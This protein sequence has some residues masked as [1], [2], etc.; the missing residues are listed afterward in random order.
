MDTNTGHRVVELSH[1][2]EHQMTTYPGLP[3]PEVSD[4]LSR[5][6]S[7]QTYPSGTEF[8]IGRISLV[9]NTGTYLDAPFHRY[10][11]GADLSALDLSR[12]AHLPGV[13][14]D[15]TGRG[16][17][18]GPDAFAGHA[19]TDHAV[20]VRT[21]WDRHW[22]TAHY[23]APE[24]PFL[25]IEAVAW[26]V[27]QRAALVGIDSVNID[28]MVDL[29]RPAHTGLLGAGIPIVEHLRGLDQLPDSG[30][31]FHAAP[32]PVRGMGSFPIRAYAVVG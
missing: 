18:I 15:A 31:R 12:L 4:H 13:L 17:A 19:V 5:G 25:T 29:R 10:P 26:L 6:A 11:E 24:H 27:A 22:R 21:G 30:F 20:L 32:A 1:V 8:Q 28:D 14:V 16:R 2:I 23:G 3:G 7:R 9:A